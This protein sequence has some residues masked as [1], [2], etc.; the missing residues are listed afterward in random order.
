MEHITNEIALK[1]KKQRN[2]GTA[3]FKFVFTLGMEIVARRY[4]WQYN[5][6]G[7]FLSLN[8]SVYE[9]NIWNLFVKKQKRNH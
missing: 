4:N 1:N 9:E 6:L 3:K 7:I 8:G 5:K 2:Y